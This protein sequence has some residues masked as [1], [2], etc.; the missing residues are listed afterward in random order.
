VYE[1]VGAFY[2]PQPGEGNH[3]LQDYTSKSVE[4]IHGHSMHAIKAQGGE[5]TLLDFAQPPFKPDQ[6]A[7]VQ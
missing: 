2:A 7:W 3:I 6:M 5:L 4:T 1:W